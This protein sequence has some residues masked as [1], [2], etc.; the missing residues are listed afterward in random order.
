MA[1]TVTIA[2]NVSFDSQGGHNSHVGFKASTVAIA[3]SISIVSMVMIVMLVSMT[4]VVTIAINVGFEISM[5]TIAINVGF[6]S[7]YSHDSHID[8]D[9]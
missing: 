3:M 4:R 2:M 5:V 9:G 6:N 8:F 7:Q 1:S